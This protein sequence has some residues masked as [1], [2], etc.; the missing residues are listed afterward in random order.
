MRLHF[1]NLVFFL[2]LGSHSI[3]LN[4]T[5]TT[6]HHKLQTH[7]RITSFFTLDAVKYLSI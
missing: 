3:H 4:G 1:N 5:A 7:L 2:K 6:N